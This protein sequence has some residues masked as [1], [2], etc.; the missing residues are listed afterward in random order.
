MSPFKTIILTTDFSE[1]SRKAVAPAAM[2]AK[3]FGAKLLLFHVGDHVPPTLW[4][5]PGL[6]V[7]ALE[8]RQLEVAREQL[9]RFAAANLK[10][11]KNV[12]PIVVLGDA[13]VEIVRLAEE[14]GADLIVMATH[15]RNFF[16]H[17]VMGSTTERV[18][19]RSPCPVLAVRDAKSKDAWFADASA[20]SSKRP[21]RRAK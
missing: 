2:L 3:V 7:Q 12:D 13:H 18:L 14:R 4:E 17:A 10:N 20:S 6:D 9:K 5:Y 21:R 19:R 16:S 11:I 1:T 8:D 15:G